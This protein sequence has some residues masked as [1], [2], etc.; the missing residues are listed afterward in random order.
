MIVTAEKQPQ[1]RI[2]WGCM[3][4]FIFLFYPIYRGLSTTYYG[5]SLSLPLSPQ[6]W[7]LLFDA[8]L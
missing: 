7:H 1:K 5:E 6:P 4:L 8:V 2:F 3:Y